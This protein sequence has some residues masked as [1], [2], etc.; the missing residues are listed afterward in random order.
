M[1]QD[2]IHQEFNKMHT[3]LHSNVDDGGI[4]TKLHDQLIRLH[5]Q[6]RYF[7]QFRDEALFEENFN[8]VVSNFNRDLSL[9]EDQAFAPL[10]KKPL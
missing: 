7:E 2:S 9:A 5:H 3:F 6:V 10:Q 8:W 4:K 1:I